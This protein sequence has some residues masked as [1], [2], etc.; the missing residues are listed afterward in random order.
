M[1][2]PQIVGRRAGESPESADPRSHTKK[3]SEG[4][5]PYLD[6]VIGT[7]RVEFFASTDDEDRGG[8]V[9]RFSIDDQA[10]SFVPTGVNL[11]NGVDLHLAG[12]AEA[13]AMLRAMLGAIT[14]SKSL[15]QVAA[16]V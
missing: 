15:N 1:E 9:L 8:V 10:S 3:I 13:E 11:L 6:A 16:A 14:A 5:V 7:A 2:A 4:A 12:A